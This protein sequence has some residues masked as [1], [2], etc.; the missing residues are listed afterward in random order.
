MWRN[1][2]SPNVVEIN[3]GTIALESNWTA[4]GKA[5][6][7]PSVIQ[8]LHVRAVNWETCACMLNTGKMLIVAWITSEETSKC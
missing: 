4:S 3:A 2:N 7:V 1:D 6:D 5:E 8:P